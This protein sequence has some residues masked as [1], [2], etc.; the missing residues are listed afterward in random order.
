MRRGDAYEPERLPEDMVGQNNQRFPA[1]AL[2]EIVLIQVDERLSIGL[3]T[4]AIEEMGI[5]DRVMMRKQ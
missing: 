3:V 1:R 2:G 4:L 5:G